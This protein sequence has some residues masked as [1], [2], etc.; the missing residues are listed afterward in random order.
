MTITSSLLTIAFYLLI[1]VPLILI[2]MEKNKMNNIRIILFSFCFILYSMALRVSMFIEVLRIGNGNWSGKIIAIVLGCLCFVIFKK[3]F[4]ENNF[5]TRKQDTK[6]IKSVIIVSCITILLLCIQSLFDGSEQPNSIEYLLFE[7]LMPG[8][9]EEIMFRGI[10]LGLLL[11]S[12]KVRIPLI[13]NPSLLMISLLFGL[14][15]GLQIG[16]DF[17]FNIDP[18]TIVYTGILGYILGWITIKTKSILF[19]IIMHNAFNFLP[20][21]ILRIK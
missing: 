20:T 10:L 17:S 21:L 6:N 1:F 18:V 15:H 8:I 3:Y 19:P 2:F 9:D 11:S 7:L 4:N 13:G 16:P 14:G 12:I 5:F